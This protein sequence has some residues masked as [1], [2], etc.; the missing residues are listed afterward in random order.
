MTA[1]I[2]DCQDLSLPLVTVGIPTYNRASTLGRA[3]ESVLGQDYPHI[4]VV[5]SDNASTDE[6]QAICKEFQEADNRVRYIRQLSNQGATANFNQVLQQ[7]SGDFF[8][9]LGDDDWLDRGYI[10]NCIRILLEEP[11]KS[12]ICGQARYFREGKFVYEGRKLDLL[13][14]SGRERMLAYYR[15][16]EGNET[17][18]GVMRRKDL[19]RVALQNTMGGDWLLIATIAFMGKVITL[20]NITINRQLGGATDSYQ[21]IASILGLS[22]FQAKNPHL[23][24]ALVAFKDIGW[25]SPVYSICGKIGRFVLAYQSLELI[26]GKFVV[27]PERDRIFWEIRKQIVYILEK[28]LPQDIFTIVKNKYRERQN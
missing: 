7:A 12:L 23:S 24:I 9:W 2:E 8:M 19:S 3:I 22:N 28:I 1:A 27:G 17:F 21:K 4:E 16:V 15:Q 13:Q 18:Y 25:G 20:E 11:D 14:D 6:T 26:L 5:I 10:S